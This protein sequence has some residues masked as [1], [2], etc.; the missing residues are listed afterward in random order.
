MD[1]LQPA[2]SELLSLKSTNTRINAAL[3]RLNASL[4]SIALDAAG[5]GGGDTG[6]QTAFAKSQEGFGHN[7]E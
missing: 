3:V 5:Q 4:A 1:D 2:L 6:S 7:G